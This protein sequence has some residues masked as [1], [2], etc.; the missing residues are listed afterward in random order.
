MSIFLHSFICLHFLLFLMVGMS[1]IFRL[2]LKEN[3]D[4][5]T[6]HRKYH[7]CW[8]PGN[9][10]SQSINCHSINLVLTEY[11]CLSAKS[12]ALLRADRWLVPDF[13]E[14]ISLKHLNGFSQFEV[15]WNCL[16]LQ[17]CSILCICPFGPYGLSQ[18]SECLYP[19]YP[20]PLDV[21]SLLEVLWKWLH[22]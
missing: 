6:S 3:K 18:G 1:Q 15:L 19:K 10:R 5:H 12:V 7:G 21:F 9:T 2:T 16:D 14:C 4:I 17:L 20:K 22:L 8:W 11:C 13:A